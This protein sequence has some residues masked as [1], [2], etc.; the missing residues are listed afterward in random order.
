MSAKCISKRKRKGLSKQ[1]KCLESMTD[2]LVPVVRSQTNT[3]PDSTPLRTQPV[4]VEIAILTELLSG[5]H[6]LNNV[7][8]WRSYTMMELGDEVFNS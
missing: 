8:L 2:F 5:F 1:S 4:C 3:S 7:P 6:F